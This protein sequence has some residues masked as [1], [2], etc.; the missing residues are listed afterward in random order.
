MLS[1]ATTID[2]YSD[3]DDQTTL[4]TSILGFIIMYF[5][6]IISKVALDRVYLTLVAIRS[7]LE[8]TR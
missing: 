8:L 7:Q 2:N 5:I 4:F 6:L 3:P 1:V